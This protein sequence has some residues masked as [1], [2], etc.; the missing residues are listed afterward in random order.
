MPEGPVQLYSNAL[1]LVQAKA[2]EAYQI[3]T[4]DITI[5]DE[6]EHSGMEAS[7]LRPTFDLNDRSAFFSLTWCAG[8]IAHDSFHSK[9]YHDYQKS[10]GGK[11]PDEIWIGHEAERRCLRHQ[12][13][14]LKEIGAPE[15]EITYCAGLSPAYADVPYTNRN[16]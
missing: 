11:V 9:L 14:V 8:V 2:P 15:S 1:L 5:I 13:Q 4:N 16:W 6:S 10:H 3:I 7:L 12:V